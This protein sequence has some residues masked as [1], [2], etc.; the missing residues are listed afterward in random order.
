MEFGG[1]GLFGRNAR[2][3]GPGGKRPVPGEVRVGVSA[4]SVVAIASNVGRRIGVGPLGR[5]RWRLA[6]RSRKSRCGRDA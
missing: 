4:R 3:D 2:E 5:C 6:G 1:C